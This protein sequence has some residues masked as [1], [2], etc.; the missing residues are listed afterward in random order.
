MG[1]VAHKFDDV[2]YDIPISDNSSIPV[3]G[4]PDLVMA[5]TD[6]IEFTND[7]PYAVSITFTTTSGTVFNNIANI[8]PNGATSPMQSPQKN[9]VT[10]NYIMTNLTTNVPSTP[11]AIQVGVGPLRINILAGNTNPDPVSI[12]DSGEIQFFPRPGIPNHDQSAERV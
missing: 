4:E 2:L 12:P 5:S 10:V 7:A 9:N 8:A 11:C 6:N 3:S 1:N